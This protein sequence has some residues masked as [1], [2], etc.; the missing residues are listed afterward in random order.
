MR[1]DEEHPSETSV[2]CSDRV[3]LECRRCGERLVLLGLEEDWYKEGRTAFSCGG[4]EGRVTLADRVEE[5]DAHVAAL[6]HGLREEYYG[7]L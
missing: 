5:E 6:L 3:L 4:C 2:S 1:Y 7:G